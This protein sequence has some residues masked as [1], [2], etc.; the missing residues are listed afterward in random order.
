MLRKLIDGLIS[1][2]GGAPLHDGAAL[3]GSSVIFGVR[4]RIAP[5]IRH[6]D[7]GLNTSIFFK[8]I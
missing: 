8:Q 1:F 3:S 4:D 6:F 5:V 7:L 2:R